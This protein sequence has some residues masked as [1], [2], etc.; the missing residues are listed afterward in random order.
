MNGKNYTLPDNVEEL[1]IIDTN[2]LTEIK[3]SVVE[4]L[5]TQQQYNNLETEYAVLKTQHISL[6]TQHAVLGTQHA[7]L[8]TQHAD[9][10]V[11]Y[12]DLKNKYKS[13]QKYFF[14]KSSEKLTPAD[15][16]QGF[17]FNEAESSGKTLDDDSNELKTEE[18]AI[19]DDVTVIKQYTRRK[20]GRKPI[21]AHIPRKEI[22]HDLSDEEKACECCDKCRPLIG[23]K[24][25][26][27]LEFKPAEIFV[28]KHIYPIYGPCDCEDCIN[29]EKPEVISATAPKRIIPGSIASESLIAYIITSKFCDA[30]PFYRQSKM[31]GRIDIDISRATM[32]NWQMDAF[33]GMDLFFEVMKETL[34]GGEFIRMDE[35]TV[36]VLHE[37]NRAPESKSYMWVAIGY[38]ARGRRLILYEYHPTRSGQ[39]PME[40]LK[41]FNGYLQTDGYAAYAAPAMKYGLI[42]VGCLAHARREFHKAYDPKAKKSS[43]YKALMIIR[44]VYEIE[45]DLREKDLS[46]DEFVK[47]RKAAVTPVLDELYEF[48]VRTK[49]LVTPSSL[50][51]VAVTYTLNQWSKLIR[52]LDLACMTP[53]N[54]EIERSIKSFVIGRKN[55]MF[56]NTSRGAN[57]SAGM[58]SLIES[59]KAN[60]L[61]PYLYLRFLFTK[62]PYV[63]DNKDELRKLL[64]CFLSP[65]DIK[66]SD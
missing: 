38:P 7:D 2:S 32:C 46:D 39:V 56:S 16:L 21:P 34:K 31:F 22:I 26:E 59:A 29:E 25:T 52:Y 43:A 45:S 47:K 5:K 28:L 1:K 40:F 57:A 49:E 27:E 58:Y 37:D 13:L 66:I 18:E 42:H 54:N 10:E 15:E 36:Q 23:T 62:L 41:G 44:K 4:L 48:L 6:E 14:G 61:D 19:A 3:S 20:A 51:G 60:G 9:L 35:T 65:E 11:Q 24:A 63:R 12:E 8:E 50:V 17:L 53:D 55:W 33:E 64:P 30:I